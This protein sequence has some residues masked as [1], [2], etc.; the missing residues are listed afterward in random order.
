MT[1]PRPGEGWRMYDEAYLR[2]GVPRPHYAG[3]LEEL[4]SRDLS[5]LQAQAD[6]WVA[7]HGV[8]FAG[9]PFAIDPVPRVLTAA[10]WSELEAGLVQ[11]VRALNAYVR[12]VHGERRIVEEG[13]VPA[14]LVAF[15]D[16]H[17]PA[18]A[19]LAEHGANPIAVAGLDVVRD[20]DGRFLVLEDNVR[21]PSGLACAIAARRASDMLLPGHPP[22]RDVEPVL[23]L[24]AAALRAAA[25]DG[26]DDPFVVQVSD[27]P[28]NPAWYEHQVISERLGIPLLRPTDLEVRDGKLAAHLDGRA[29][30]I[31]VVY[32]RTN[33][34][35]L[36][37]EAGRATALGS[38]MLE[39]LRR[40]TV[41][42]ANTFGAGVAD[43]KLAHAYVERMIAFYLGE[44][45]LV[46]SVPT[47]D[48]AD[49]DARGDVLDRID[50]MVVKPRAASGGRGVVVGPHATEAD[51]ERTIRAVSADPEAFV[52]QE[53]V[54]LSR[55]PTVVDGR[56]EP[57]HVD[58]RAFA[59]V[60]GD[61]VAALPGGLTRVALEP[62]ALVV[63]S[64]QDGGAKDTW[65]LA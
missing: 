16:H 47:F 55:H 1:R 33:E 35:R 4:G 56:L 59:F 7:V 11:R 65:V 43:D 8:T 26:V 24:L 63:N 17:E 22:L 27:G 6:D 36:V 2:P 39:P 30:R 62:G 53:T 28:S 23:D 37:D 52:A 57:R 31:D 45:P 9:A 18:M 14:A 29:R 64:S 32:R 3:L 10:E 21:T 25:P 58:L 20:A 19:G 42:C 48:L 49:A 44:E 60:T 5:E 61:G 12:D 13:V 46:R 40:G 54:W 15:A 38:V 50:E 41:G 51:R 34:E